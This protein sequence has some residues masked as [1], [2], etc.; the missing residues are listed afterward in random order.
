MTRQRLKK[1]ESALKKEI[2]NA[3]LYESD[4]PFLKE[5]VITDVEVSRDLKVANV[6]FTNYLHRDADR[7]DMRRR[8]QKAAPYFIQ[9]LKARIRMKFFPQLRFTYDTSMEK[10]ERIEEVLKEIHE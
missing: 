7:E 5:V 1:V 8:L 2:A 10:A 3:C 6:Y 4:N 9:I